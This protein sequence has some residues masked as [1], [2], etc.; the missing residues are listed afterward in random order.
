MGIQAENMGDLIFRHN[1]NYPEKEEGE[2]I[3]FFNQTGTS[4]EYNFKIHPLC[5]AGGYFRSAEL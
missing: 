1:F 2:E 4:P 5:V 3:C